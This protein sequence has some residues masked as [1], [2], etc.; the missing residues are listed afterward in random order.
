M[1]KRIQIGEITTT[2]GVRGLVK[3]RVMAE[4]E[5]LLNGEL[6]T[7]E[8]GSNT[9]TITLKN[10]QNK[11]W[12]AEVKGYTD[13]TAADALRHTPLYIDRGALPEAADGEFYYDDLVGLA[14][15][16][17]DGAPIGKVIGVDNFG[18][19]DLLEIQPL[20]GPSFY[21]PFVDEYVPDISEAAVTVIIPEG[22]LE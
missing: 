8:S 21:L 13:K 16:D 19:S 7:S 20:K 9:L 12:L 2:H 6:Y 5:S 1:T 14:V 17:P 18:A 22:L 3:I 11:V 10:R 15:V 4:D